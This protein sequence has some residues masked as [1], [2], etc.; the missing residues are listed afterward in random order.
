MF[1]NNDTTIQVDLRKK[2]SLKEEINYKNID[3]QSCM[4]VLVV[5]AAL[6]LSVISVVAAQ[7][8][9]LL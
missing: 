3:V 8:P 2:S 5:I 4:V 7:N 9:Y 1:E 6:L